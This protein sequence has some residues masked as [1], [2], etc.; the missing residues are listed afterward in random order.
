M[1]RQYKDDYSSLTPTEWI[2]GYPAWL[3]E[4]VERR[5][6]EPEAD[7]LPIYIQIGYLTPAGEG[8]AFRWFT[9]SNNMRGLCLEDYGRAVRALEDRNNLIL[10]KSRLVKQLVD[11]M[12]EAD[13]GKIRQYTDRGKAK[14]KQRK[15]NNE[16]TR[17]QAKDLR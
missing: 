13:L 16:N 2:N 3:R 9:L 1:T 11:G 7:C 8:R 4:E 17:P 6:E 10:P 15:W 5:Q 14:E 12:N